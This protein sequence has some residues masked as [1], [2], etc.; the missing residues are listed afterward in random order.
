MDAERVGSIVEK[1]TL[2]TDMLLVRAGPSSA[3]TPVH[4]GG[5]S[6]A[7]GRGV[8]PQSDV[9]VLAPSGAPEVQYN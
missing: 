9:T 4:G 3:G 1:T 8:S 6:A 7:L 5:I 2:T